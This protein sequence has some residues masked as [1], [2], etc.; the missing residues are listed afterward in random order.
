MD[1]LLEA[2]PRFRM[3]QLEKVRRKMLAEAEAAGRLDN[4][5]T[6]LE[7]ICLPHVCLT[8]EEGRHP[9]AAFMV[10]YLPRYQ[11]TGFK[12]YMNSS[13]A[14]LPSLNRLLVLLP[15]LLPD[16]P[17][18]VLNRRLTSATLHFLNVLIAHDIE[19]GLTAH[20]PGAALMLQD[21]LS[22][23]TAAISVPFV[24]EISADLEW[25]VSGAEPV[26]A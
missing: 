1:G 11:P 8:D 15:G 16:L 12:W 23:I 3:A 13:D 6:L 2:I 24:P 25:I 17:R 7:I 18:D 19:E 20:D 4:I 14:N 9:Y 5:R 22:Q 10:Q 26:S 21:C